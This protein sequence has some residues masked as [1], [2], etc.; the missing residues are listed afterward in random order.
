MII[1]NKITKKTF[2]KKYKKSDCLKLELA[3]EQAKAANANISESD[4]TAIV[5][6]AVQW[7]RKH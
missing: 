7:A 6:E 4:L 2:P 1:K 3:A 5:A